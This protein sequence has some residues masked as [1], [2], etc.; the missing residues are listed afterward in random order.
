MERV[1]RPQSLQEK[2]HAA[3]L[4][5]AGWVKRG[6]LTEAE[7]ALRE[8]L[9]LDPDA[10]DAREVLAAVL[11]REQRSPEAERVLQAGLVR[12]P[13]AYVLAR[14]QARILADRNEAPA[15]IRTLETALPAPALDPDYYALLAALYQRT[16]APHKAAEAYRRALAVVP[17]RGVWWMGLGI[18]L[19]RVTEP[20]A[21][22]QAY[23]RARTASG[24]S[25]QLL[26]FVEGRIAV[27]SGES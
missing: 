24:M 13:R 8:A 20:A 15:A 2:A 22:L 9:V 4:R 17:E 6:R 12:N 26:N 3:Y 14:M 7:T 23:R 10:V 16:G 21:A 19:E 5:G 25:A 27:L 18:S 1:A 11:L